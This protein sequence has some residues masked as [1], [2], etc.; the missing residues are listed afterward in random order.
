VLLLVLGR[1]SAEAA[2]AWIDA[3]TPDAADWQ[4][5]SRVAVDF[6]AR[7]SPAGALPFV[8][9]A[10]PA[11]NGREGDRRPGNG[12]QGDGRPGNGRWVFAHYFPPYPLSLDNRPLDEDVYAKAYLRR[13]GENGK[14]YAQGGLARTRP[15]PAG[16]WQ[17][18]FWVQ[19]ND[20]IEILRARR[21]G[22]DGFA[23]D[24][25]DVHQGRWGVGY[26]LML[27]T[28]ARVA[29]GFKIVAEPDCNILA[30][31]TAADLA[32]V[33]ST[34]WGHVA[35]F[36]LAD[37]RLLVAPFAAAGKPPAFWQELEADMAQRGQPIALLPVLLDANADAQK[38]ASLSYGESSWGDRDPQLPDVRLR[39]EALHLIPAD[40]VWMMPVSPQDAR[41]NSSIFWEADNT[42]LYRRQWLEAI[43]NGSQFI[44][45]ITW[46][47]V[48]ESTQVEP[49]SA[50]QFVFYDLGMFYAA[51]FKTR[52]MPRI[53]RD[54]IYYTHR[55]EIF[56]PD[57]LP[58][59]GDR[60]MKQLGTS[61][62]SNDIE[63]LAFLTKPATLEIELNGV[64]RRQSSAA[65][66]GEFRLPAE[67]GTPKFRIIRAGRVIVETTS[68]W[69]IVE[70][71]TAL[72]P[73]YAGGSSNRPAVLAG[74]AVSRG[75]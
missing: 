68:I 62:L 27:D 67:P 46:N 22:I 11:G 3:P 60:P 19:L 34:A 41:P 59:T 55:R 51:W 47:D 4:Q 12:H 37:G 32:T 54:A 49:S 39:L 36:H 17:S 35:S 71:E 18:P 44:Q 61:P 40:G 65:G 21:M 38:F 16:P 5:I 50:T 30:D 64:R 20:A 10:S 15:L 6:V 42:R 57:R 70:E 45:L 58:Q 9:R 72:D 63:M 13:D 7:E 31:A 23:Y 8:I 43:G 48:S 29:P 28:A 25:V 53:V 1:A 56:T 75:P 66:I 24:I 33:L 74:A 69:P 52:R 2:D 73:V 14:F 26:R